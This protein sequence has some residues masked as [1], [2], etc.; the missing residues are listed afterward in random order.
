M[1]NILDYIEQMKDMY[2]GPRI[3][4][5][6]P[7]NMDQ[8]ALVD[9]LEPGALKDEMLGNFDP[10]QET[11]EDYLRRINLERPFN[12]AEGGVIG[13]P[14]G[15]VEPGVEY[16]SNVKKLTPTHEK[17]IAKYNEWAKKNKKPLYGSKLTPVWKRY[18]IR[19]GNWTGGG[20][21]ERFKD[22]KFHRLLHKDSQIVKV[23]DYLSKTYRENKYKPLTFKTIA[24]IKKKAGVTAN[25]D[26][27][28]TRE[29]QSDKFRNK[30]N[31]RN[32]DKLPD[33]VIAEIK[34]RF[35]DI[36]PKDKWNFDKYKYGINETQYTN[37]VYDRVRQLVKD[38]TPTRYAFGFNNAEGWM[39]AQMDR[40]WRSGNKDYKPIY[41]GDG[42]VI[43]YIDNTEKGGG[44]KWF[45]SDE[46]IKGK[47]SDGLLLKGTNKYKAHGDYADNLKFHSIVKNAGQQPN[48][49]ITQIL[50]A[51]GILDQDAMYTTK[52]GTRQPL[53]L[54]HVLNY[55]LDNTNASA[56]RNSIVR[57]HR[58]QL[59]NATSDLQ[60]LNRVQNSKVIG[61]E[62]RIAANNIKP[63]DVA[64]LK[65]W[66]VSVRDPN[67]GILYGRGPTTAEGGM[68]KI[69]ELILKGSKDVD[70]YGREIK[71][72]EQ[73]KK[74]D[75]NKF[76]TY[77]KEL[78][79]KGKASGGRIGY[80]AA[81]AV[82]GTL[83]CGINELDKYLKKGVPETKRNLV[84]R[85]LSS[86]KNLIK[87]AG[88]T[89]N[90]VEFFKLKNWIG[91][92]AA[93]AMGAF[94]TGMV[95]DDVLR[96][97]KP[98]NESTAENWLFGN[99]LDMDAQVEEAKN[100]LDNPNLSPAAKNYA[101]SIID[102]KRYEDLEN[103]L[104]WKYGETA[105]K[106]IES[107][108]NTIRHNVI[109]GGETG[110]F[111]YESVLADKQDAR[112][113]GEYVGEP[114]KRD[115]RPGWWAKDANDEWRKVSEGGYAIK[116]TTL[117]A[118]DK[119]ES[120]PMKA[121]VEPSAKRD[122]F[123]TL[124]DMPPSPF[125][126]DR[127]TVQMVPD[128]KKPVEPDL[129]VTREEV[130]RFYQDLGYVH[131]IGGEVPK[132]ILDEI[133]ME[134][135]TKYWSQLMD[136]ER[137]RPLGKFAGGGIAGIRRPNAIP[138]ERGGLRSIMI[139][140]RKS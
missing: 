101:K 26:S 38:P 71:G 53:Q 15:L 111:D 116:G 23:R 88:Q 11:Y 47:H 102:I 104:G 7:R 126:A 52:I 49:A 12:M 124:F 130:N 132:E 36:V 138:P 75:F 133:E 109:H 33:E 137:M 48:K 32:F 66:G 62:E 50:K 41:R 82:T 65:R 115:R 8:A 18:D 35:D 63:D 68:K 117:D 72:I 64:K 40:A 45:V 46:H 79:P 76:K 25:I 140:G 83:Q 60:I 112:S 54:R 127:G 128:L 29:L 123:K 118:A 19:E 81:G 70:L 14:G 39:L 84:A 4:A 92:P 5:Q 100:M 51:G 34:T 58:G 10:S 30:I 93:I 110:R 78:C 122:Y 87:G 24:E 28:I 3:T 67:T 90:P 97:G 85:I 9:E 22:P 114:V 113:A 27:D 94:E 57:H 86:G 17:R 56:A 107:E 108:M 20:K 59:K 119:I 37:K 91:K 6:E 139:N 73:W 42:R 55:I 69:N 98:L 96:K 44:K 105:R 74:Q 125:M 106:D 103:K 121:V 61:I 80:K 16:Y 43:G 131:P 134:E 135:K 129:P 31:L 1:K 77:L 99:V 136:Q 13:K 2:E 95:L 21:G 120:R 89:I